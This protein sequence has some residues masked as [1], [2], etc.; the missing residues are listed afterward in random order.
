MESFLESFPGELALWKAHKTWACRKLPWKFQKAV[1]KLAQSQRLRK[2]HQVSE[3]M[4]WDGAAGAQQL[5]ETLISFSPVELHSS[6]RLQQLFSAK[7]NTRDDG[8][9]GHV[10]V[11]GISEADMWWFRDSLL[12]K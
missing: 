2:A 1:R 7:A 3:T 11:L 5:C 9:L 6:D 8:H 12:S 4:G 10:T